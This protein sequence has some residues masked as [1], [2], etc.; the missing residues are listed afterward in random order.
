MLYGA[1][2]LCKLDEREIVGR[3]FVVTSWHTRAMLDLIEDP[4]NAAQP[5]G[6]IGLMA[7]HSWSMSS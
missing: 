3:E 5:I 1:D 4:W 7:A 2:S 6:S